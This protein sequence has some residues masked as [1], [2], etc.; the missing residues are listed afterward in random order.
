M[1]GRKRP[2]WDEYALILAHAASQRSE[3]PWRQVG[4]AALRFDNSTA[5]T[6]YNGLPPGVT[7]D[8]SDRE[9]R[10]KY[11]IHSERNCLNYVKPGE[12]RLLACTHMPCAECL[13]EI[14][15]KRIPRVVYAEE[16]KRNGILSVDEEAQ[17][18]IARFKLEVVHLP[19]TS[20]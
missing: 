12:C 2:N 8:W 20:T 14:A 11:I 7:I 19:Y 13:L 10:Q 4:A 16:Y 17:E 5:A 6:G 3:D 9:A 18:L 1:N 15:L